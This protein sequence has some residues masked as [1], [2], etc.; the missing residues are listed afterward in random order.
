[1]TYALLK[2][3]HIV[4]LALIWAG[5]IGAFE[6]PW[7]AGMVALFG[8]EFV[9]DNTVTRLYFMKWRRLTRQALEPGQVTPELEQAQGKTFRLLLTFSTSLSSSPSS[10]SALSG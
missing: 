6:V 3:V 5:L 8:F 9:D 1:M 2:F 10:P 7:L 4:G